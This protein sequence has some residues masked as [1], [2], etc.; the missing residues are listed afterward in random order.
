MKKA[1]VLVV[2]AVGGLLAWR[3]VAEQQATREVWAEVTD[4]LP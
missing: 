2:V 4:P 3:R 1:L